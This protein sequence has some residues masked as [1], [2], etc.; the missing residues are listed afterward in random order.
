M[1]P[2]IKSSNVWKSMWCQLCFKT[3]VSFS[4]PY[5][6]LVG[7]EYMTYAFDNESA[8]GPMYTCIYLLCNDQVV[9]AYEHM[10]P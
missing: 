3:Y 4:I 1:G 7:S 8:C 6:D 2:A 5:L 9:V 10:V